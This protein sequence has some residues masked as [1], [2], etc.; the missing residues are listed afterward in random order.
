[1]LLATELTL[2]QELIIGAIAA[3]GAVVS[4]LIGFVASLLKSFK[5]LSS[6]LKSTAQPIMTTYE[7]LKDDLGTVQSA[8]LLGQS[9]DADAR[10]AVVE[11]L[12]QA[13]GENVVKAA[14]AIKT[15]IQK[16]VDDK[17]E[18]IKKVI[19]DYTPVD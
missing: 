5:K 3:A 18:T 8:L 13:K 16:Q 17:K 14:Q 12:S 10:K 2:T 7:A 6:D 9:K 4:L 19:D 15:E 11:L 1:M